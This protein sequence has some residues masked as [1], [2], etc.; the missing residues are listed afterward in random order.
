MQKAELWALRACF[1]LVRPSLIIS[2]QWIMLMTTSM[3][4]TIKISCDKVI[5]ETVGR[6]AKVPVQNALYKYFYNKSWTPQTSRTVVAQNRQKVFCY[7]CYP[8]PCTQWHNNNDKVKLE[9][10]CPAHICCD[11]FMSDIYVL[12]DILFM[13]TWGYLKVWK[14]LCNNKYAGKWFFIA[15]DNKY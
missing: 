13:E 15:V 11:A 14:L 12:Q 8:C 5:M 3:T 2:Q 6:Q 4:T 10:K 7:C 9:T 1:F